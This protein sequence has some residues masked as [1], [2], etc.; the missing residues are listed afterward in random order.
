MASRVQWKLHARFRTGEK[1]EIISNTYLSLCTTEILTALYWDINGPKTKPGLHGRKREISLLDIGAGNCKLL[2]VFKDIASSQ[3]LLDEVYYN[4]IPRADEMIEKS[5]IAVKELTSYKEKLNVVYANGEE[6]NIS[7]HQFVLTLKNNPIENIDLS[8]LEIFTHFKLTDKEWLLEKISNY[9]L[10]TS[11]RYHREH[12][13]VKINKYMAIEKSQILIN[14][15]PEEA[16]V[17]GTDFN[18]RATCWIVKS[19]SANKSLNIL[20]N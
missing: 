5:V 2:S 10:P 9:E 11:K 16:F 18:E 6:D 8:S 14:N 7:L 20:A 19:Y 13:V 4:E 12:N 17:I 15:M 3:P 1:S